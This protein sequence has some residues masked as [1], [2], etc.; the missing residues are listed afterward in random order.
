MHDLA[1]WRYRSGFEDGSGGPQEIFYLTAD[2]V[3]CIS[4]F[5]DEAMRLIG[6]PASD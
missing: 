5:T 6:L 2:R 4:R 1:V 3:I